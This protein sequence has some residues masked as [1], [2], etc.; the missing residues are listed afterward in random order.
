MFFFS[1]QSNSIK[2][3]WF[4]FK[5]FLINL[6]KV[7]L[8]NEILFWNLINKRHIYMNLLIKVD[9]NFVISFDEMIVS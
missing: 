9:L 4:D 2:V 1:N 5:L 6:L 3:F 8:K 7:S